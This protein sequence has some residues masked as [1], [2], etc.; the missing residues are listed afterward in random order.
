MR[1]L[2]WPV[3]LAAVGAAL[4][5]WGLALAAYWPVAYALY[6]QRAL[7]TSSATLA[8]GILLTAAGGAFLAVALM[9]ALRGGRGRGDTGP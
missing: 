9:V 6:G 3:G 1:A 4:V 8:L 2:A 5:C 7:A